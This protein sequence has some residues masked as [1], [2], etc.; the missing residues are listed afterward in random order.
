MSDPIPQALFD[1]LAHHSEANSPYSY[2]DDYTN[3]LAFLHSY[4]GSHATF[5]AY[6]R[7]LERL[8]QWCALIARKAP[9]K[10]ARQDLEAYILFCQ[11]PPQHWIATKKTDRFIDKE[12]QR[13]ANPN[14][15]PFVA[16][17]KSKYSLSQK[18]L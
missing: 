11:R 14:W 8:L 2:K 12:G 6:R 13:L 17:N 15:R 4:R 10:L 16:S 7:E 18:A 3:T 1:T 5:N 9:S